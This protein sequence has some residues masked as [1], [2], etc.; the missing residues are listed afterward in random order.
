[1]MWKDFPA[2]QDDVGTKCRYNSGAE[3][4]KAEAGQA[5]IVNINLDAE[6]EEDIFALVCDFLEGI[7]SET[8]SPYSFLS[9]SP[10]LSTQL[11]SN[12]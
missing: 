11:E 7:A 9:S 4:A 8:Q 12:T 2:K 6:N 1:M 5:M 3:A 10:C